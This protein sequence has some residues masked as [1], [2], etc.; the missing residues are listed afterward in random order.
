MTRWQTMSIVDVPKENIGVTMFAQKC[1]NPTTCSEV[2]KL[3]ERSVKS[4]VIEEVLSNHRS[5]NCYHAKEGIN[6]S[7]YHWL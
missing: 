6:Q 5:C 3:E 4:S 2:C 1:R 7:T